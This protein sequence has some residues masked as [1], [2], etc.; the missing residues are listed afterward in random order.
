MNKQD[1]QILFLSL[2]LLIPYGWIWFLA[3]RFLRNSIK[4]LLNYF[5]LALVSV[6]GAIVYYSL[7]FFLGLQVLTGGIGYTIAVASHGMVTFCYLLFI[8]IFCITF[9]L[10]I[11]Y[12]IKRNK[13]KKQ[14]N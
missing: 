14:F 8:P 11:V 3:F 13:K 10:V 4:T 2:L 5:V 7:T 6:T 1:F 9:I 12:L